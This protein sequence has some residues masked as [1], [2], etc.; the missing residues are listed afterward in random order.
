MTEKSQNESYAQVLAWKGAVLYRQKLIRMLRQITNA[1]D[2]RIWNEFQ[3]VVTQLATQSLKVPHPDQTA[4]WLQQLADLTKQKEQLEVALSRHSTKFRKLQTQNRLTPNQLRASLPPN[5]ALIDLLEF[6]RQVIEVQPSG[7][8]K[9]RLERRLAAHVVCVDRPI[10]A[11]D[12][13]LAEPIDTAVDAWRRNFGKFGDREDNPGK[14][15]C[16]LIWDPIASHLQGATTVLISP[17]GVLAGIPWGALPGNEPNTYLLEERAIAVIPVPQLIPEI[18][19]A[20]S[21]GKEEPSLLVIGNVDY[22]GS[23]G[24]AKLVADA[25]SAPRG[26]GGKNSLFGQW[27]SLP[28]TE[29]EI[30]AIERSFRN[31]FKFA[32]VKEL[33]ADKATE[34]AFR[35]QA[36]KH[37]FLHI[38]THGFFAQ[39]EICSALATDKTPDGSLGHPNLLGERS[40]V[41]FNPGLLSG[42]VLAGANLP[43]DPDRD[44]GIL[45]ALEVGSLDLRHVDLVTLSA[46]ETGLGET[47]GGEG[48]LGLQRAF[49]IAGAR[50]T[51]TSLW[52][53]NDDATRALMTEFYRNLW[54][55]RLPRIE[56]L[57]AANLQC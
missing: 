56:A 50:T 24:Q 30:A 12:L 52:K 39:S 4:A 37:R 1:D 38:A 10:V 9:R 49:Q 15:L 46:C 28:Q 3:I 21:D 22:G 26:S 42:I 25:R 18:L 32:D 41:G 11:I 53:V 31:V 51:I 5:A 43:P 19:E 13:G 40:V 16:R 36:S 57:P 8:P 6:W 55:K 54:E 47:A 17:D 45:T 29:P 44:D 34:E 14:A 35:I 48:V 7:A 23:P 33:Q 27:Q 2:I 20:N